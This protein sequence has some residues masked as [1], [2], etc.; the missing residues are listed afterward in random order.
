MTLLFVYASDWI[1]YERILIFNIF[2]FSSFM[3]ISQFLNLIF[4]GYPLFDSPGS[5]SNKIKNLF[6]IFYSLLSVD[7]WWETFYVR[8]NSICYVFRSTYLKDMKKYE[9][10]ISYAFWKLKKYFSINWIL[11]ILWISNMPGSGKEGLVEV[12]IKLFIFSGINKFYI[13]SVYFYIF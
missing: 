8:C 9:K 3:R 13:L 10:F 6:T 7:F 12:S 1:I 2:R 11:N 4:V 5:F